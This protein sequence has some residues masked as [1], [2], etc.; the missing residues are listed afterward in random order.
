[1]RLNEPHPRRA[2]AQNNLGVMYDNGQGI[3]Q[4][5][6]EWL[7]QAVEDAHHR[8]KRSIVGSSLLT[9]GAGITRFLTYVGGFERGKRNPSLARI[10]K[11]LGVSLLKLLSD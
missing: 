8:S 4:D 6:F 2:G 9:A 10:A 3:P 7:P 11:A 1:M 5:Y